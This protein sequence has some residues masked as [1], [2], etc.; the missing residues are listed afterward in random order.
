MIQ[1]MIEQQQVMFAKYLRKQEE[2]ISYEHQDDPFRPL[3]ITNIEGH[4]HEL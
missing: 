3:D 2:S 4:P 1:Q